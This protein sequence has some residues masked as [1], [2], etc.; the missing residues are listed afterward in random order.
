MKAVRIREPGGPE[1]LEPTDVPMPEPA[2]GE[3]L[4]RVRCA[5]VNR[6][7]ILQR[8][9]RYPVPAGS[10]RDIPGLEFAGEIA[11]SGDGVSGWKTGDRVMGI[12]GGGGYAEYSTVPA[13]SGQAVK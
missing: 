4:V 13:A 12:L 10:P 9:G 3:V 2:A 1:V 7:D 11:A 8:L 5:G 6:A